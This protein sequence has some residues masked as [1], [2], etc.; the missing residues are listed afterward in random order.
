MD[1]SLEKL[2]HNSTNL[3]TT[4]IV[5]AQHCNYIKNNIKDCFGYVFLFNEEYM[6]N[7]IK[8]YQQYGLL[9]PNIDCFS[10]ALNTTTENY[11]CMVITTNCQKYF[12]NRIHWYKVEGYDEKKESILDVLFNDLCIE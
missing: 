10:D 11:K 8:L 4:I 12:I 5:T 7:K 2:F 9:F 6:N 1:G 3:H